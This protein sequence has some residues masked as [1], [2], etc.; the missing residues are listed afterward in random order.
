MA[1][2]AAPKRKRDRIEDDEYA[3]FLGRAIVGMERRASEDPV[4][5]A[6]F[7]TLQDEMR[8]A[9]DRSGARL[10]SEAGFSLGE[11]ANFLTFEGHKMTRQNAVKRWGPSAMAR[12]LGIPSLTARINERRKAVQDAAERVW[13]AD[14]LA[15]RRER[16]KAV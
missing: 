1:R 2:H 3:K 10:H 12:K 4:A 9:I 14:E 16:R 15:A 11:I 8:A 7:L 13:G 5:L 6:Y